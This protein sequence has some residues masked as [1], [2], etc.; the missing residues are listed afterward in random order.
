MKGRIIL[1]RKNEKY[2]KKKEK[3]FQ[4]K[5]KEFSNME[6]FKFL[7]I[8]GEKT[9]FMISSKGRL[10]STNYNKSGE[11]KQLKTQLNKDLHESVVI[12]FK[13]KNYAVRIHRLVAEA[14]IPN[15]DNKPEVHHMDGNSLNNDYNNLQWVTPEEHK[16]LTKDLHQYSSQNGEASPAC[17]YSKKK[18]DLVCRLLSENSLTLKEIS[19]STGVPYATI[20]LLRNSNSYRKDINR[21]NIHQFSNFQ[22]SKYNKKDI[23]K[24]CEYFSNHPEIC[25]NKYKVFKELSEKYNISF[26]MVRAIYY[27][28]RHTDISSHYKY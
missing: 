27:R 28:T 7:Y 10:F 22:N 13:G 26:G 23:H 19:E 16:K 12:K 8:N 24:I 4:D 25:Q 15:P 11:I 14:F 17:K 1:G 6:Q 3:E 21:E 9:T 5:L 2:K 18:M 20:N